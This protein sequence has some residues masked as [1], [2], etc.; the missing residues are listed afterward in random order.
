MV[1]NNP[2]HSSDII[3]SAQGIGKRFGGIRALDQASIEIHA[4]QVNA[5]VGENGAGKS[6]LMKIL[7]GIYQD[8][9]GQ[10]LGLDV[11]TFFGLG[12]R[13]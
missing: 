7:A 5:I 6:T 4:G 12:I 9:E 2:S 11:R 10:Q 3:L 8:Y 1:L 13:F